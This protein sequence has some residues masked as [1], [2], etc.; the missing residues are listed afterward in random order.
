MEVLK[1]IRSVASKVFL[2][3][4]LGALAVL[5]GGPTYQS[6]TEGEYVIAVGG[7]LVLVGIGYGVFWGAVSA[8]E[9]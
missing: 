2:I 5:V 6:L 7:A 4:I 1:T 8:V 9:G 3:V